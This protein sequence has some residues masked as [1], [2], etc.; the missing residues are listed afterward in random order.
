MSVSW[1]NRR[2][3]Q[4]IGLYFVPARFKSS[5]FDNREVLAILVELITQVIGLDEV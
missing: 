2:Y 4:L 5:H 3:V 1:Q